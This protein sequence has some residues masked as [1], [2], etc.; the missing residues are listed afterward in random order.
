M[1]ESVKTLARNYGVYLGVLLSIIYILV[2]FIN[3]NLFVNSTFG[4][5]LYIICV[6]FGIVA[7]AKVKQ[8]RNG[9]LSFKDCFTSYFITI[10]IGL[11]LMTLLSYI[12]FNFIDVEAAAALK[13][14]YKEKLIEVYNNLNVSKEKINEMLLQMEADNLFSFK[15]SFSTL[16]IRYI[17]PLS[18]IGLLVSAT[19]K[20]R[21][22]DTE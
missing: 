3:L 15:N 8:H 10:F 20:K 14:L 5:S 17:L 2:Y 1:G 9:Y 7:V 16:L 21:N 19:L 6:I 4:I 22:Q 18:I 11:L 12:L 13:E